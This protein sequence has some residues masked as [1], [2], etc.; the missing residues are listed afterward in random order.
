M[1]TEIVPLLVQVGT[2]IAASAVT[3]GLRA[4]FTQRVDA[5]KRAIQATCSR[6]PEIEGVET[7]LDKWT[8]AEAFIDFFERVEAGERNFDDEIIASFI[9]EGEFYLPDEE[10]RTTVARGIVAAFISELSG[11]LYGGDD[12]LPAFANRVEALHIDTKRH[13]DIRFADLEAKLSSLASPAAVPDEPTASGSLSDPAHRKLASRIDF[14]RELIDR[15]LVRS[16]RAE[17]TRIE[18]EAGPIPTEL[19]FRVV[20]N[21]GAC[22]LAEENIDDARALLEEAHR[23]WPENP[24]GVANAALA[25]SL[26]NESERAL[27]LALKAR[28]VDAQ[29]SQATAVLIGEVWEARDIDRLE[30]LVTEEDWI[31][32]DPQCGLVLAGIRMQQTRFAEAVNLLRS[33]VEADP[34]VADTHLA[35]SECL[36]NYAQADRRLVGHTNELVRRLREAESEATQAVDLLRDTELRARSQRALVVRACVRAM[37]GATDEAI[38]DF[39]EVLGDEPADA[40]AA[41]NKGLFLLYEG[42]PEESRAVLEGIRDPERRQDVTLP[43]ADACLATGDAAAAI[44]LLKGTISL[45]CLRGCLKSGGAC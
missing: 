27:E 39:D 36:L 8:S 45:D 32:Q 40:D 1:T 5:L 38:R 6:F 10:E 31:A 3:G 9:E 35:L 29:D 4:F 13:M 19:K 17:L 21:L 12:G 11:A 22:A 15:G 2:G 20:T 33:L 30:E 23:L 28:A 44:R 18:N 41:F 26:A 43:L 42:R 14:A 24:K 25:A 34:D 37:L 7:A 16:A